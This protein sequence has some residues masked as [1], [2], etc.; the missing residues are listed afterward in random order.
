MREDDYEFIKLLAYHY[1]G[2]DFGSDVAVSASLTA[3]NHLS[4]D[5]FTSISDYCRFLQEQRAS[6]AWP[7]TAPEGEPPTV[8]FNEEGHLGF[9]RGY[10]LPEFLRRHGGE[11]LPPFRV[12]TP[13]AHA[14]DE[15]YVLAMLLGQTL[16]LKSD[17]EW[18]IESSDEDPLN[19]QKARVG[20]YPESIIASLPSKWVDRYFQRGF[21]PQKGNYRIKPRIQERITFREFDFQNDKLPYKTPFNVI[22]CRNTLSGIESAAQAKL[23]AIFQ[24]LLSPGGYLLLGSLDP[25]FDISPLELFY[26]SAYRKPLIS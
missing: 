12:W 8:R 24:G 4:A 14:G 16:G 2:I 25:I 5:N 7:G 3:E 19:L 17:S 9:L 26:P 21:G 13:S 18:S 11:T 1:R 22:F 23:V 10:V 20:I 15:T 6:D